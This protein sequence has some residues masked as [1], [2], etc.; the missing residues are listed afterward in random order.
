MTPNRQPTRQASR[1]RARRQRAGS[2]A[3]VMWIVLGVVV[4]LGIVAIAV[5]RDSTKKS[6]A[7]AEE[8]RPVKVTG[9]SLAMMPR[10]GA[11]ADPAIG[12]TAPQIKGSTFT[13]KP[14]EITRDGKPK[15][16]VFVAHWCPHCQAEVPLLTEHFAKAGVPG[17]V[18]AVSTGVN[19]NQP[20]YPP[21][22]WLEDEEWPIPTMADDADGQ[23]AAA[24]GL[25]GFPYYVAIDASGKV[26]ARTSGEISTEQFDALVAQAGA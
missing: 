20:N 17:G 5:S 8:N 1:A 6:A 14:I 9:T 2:G 12:A 11:G 25:P 21:S 24:F 23:A 16:V 26:V 18:Y 13:G 4:V 19:K 15:V 3:P 7:G 10:P 22:A